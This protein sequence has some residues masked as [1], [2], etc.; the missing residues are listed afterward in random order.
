MATKDVKSLF[1][2]LTKAGYSVTTTKNHMRISDPAKKAR[3]FF[4]SKTPSEER[5]LQNALADLRKC[6][7][8]F[9]FR[10]KKYNC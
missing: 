3:M 9:E 5:G 10:G 7:Y 6:G 2:V 1:E 8:V 4:T